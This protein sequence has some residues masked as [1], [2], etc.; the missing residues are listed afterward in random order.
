MKRLFYLVDSIDSVDEISDDLHKHGVTDWRFHIVSKDEAGL[1]RH[2]LHTASILDRTDLP[3]FVERGVLIGA[4]AGVLVVGTLSLIIGLSFP[5]GAW[6]ALFAFSVVA[7]GWLAGFG[8]IQSENYRIRRFH[9]D[10]EA[11]KYLV[12]VDVPKQDEEE[13]KRLMGARHPE[14]VLQGEG[15]SFNNPFAGLSLHRKARAH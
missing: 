6:I 5:M 12:M 10:I 2:H 15:S 1:F 13:M 4:L 14:A 8:G 7:G 9:D 11:G 3:R